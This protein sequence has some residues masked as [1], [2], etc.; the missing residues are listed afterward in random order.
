MDA[1]H[2]TLPDDPRAALRFIASYLREV[3]RDDARRITKIQVTPDGMIPEL[4][5]YW[6]TPEYLDGLDDIVRECDRIESERLANTEQW[7]TFEYRC[8][9]AVGVAVLLFIVVGTLYYAFR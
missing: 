9:I 2:I 3:R 1:D 5:G 4:A 6:Q 8:M 7:A